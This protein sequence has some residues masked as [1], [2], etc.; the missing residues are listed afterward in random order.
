MIVDEPYF[1]KNK[2]WYKEN[3]GI[4][5]F[6][7]GTV[8]KKYVLTKKAPLKA[9]DSYNKYYE[10]IYNFQSIDEIKKLEDAK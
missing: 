10:K 3:K 2:K 8:E 5:S 4:P 1:L 9:I 7:G 6:L